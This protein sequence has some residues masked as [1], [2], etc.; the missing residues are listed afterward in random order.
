MTLEAF[1][2]I[3]LVQTLLYGLGSV[4]AFV[5]FGKRSRYILAIGALCLASVLGDVISHVLLSFRINPNYSASVY[6]ILA[7]P[8]VSMIYFS[9]TNNKNKWTFIL[10][11]SLYLLFGI[12]NLLFIQQQTINSYT[13]IMMSIIILIYCL[14]YFYWLLKELP[15]MH[16][17]K[18]P[19]FWINSAFMIYFAGN[20]FLFVF[21]SYL[22]SVLKDNLLVYWSLHNFLG[23]IEMTMII[24]ALWMDLQNIKLHSS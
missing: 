18:L 24:F 1:L 7:L 12:V 22:V 2:R 19:M 17:H 8:I 20:L 10:I 16:L 3:A 13:L 23:I 9:V 6:H 21:T 15:T 5:Y 14:Y 4:F 11:A